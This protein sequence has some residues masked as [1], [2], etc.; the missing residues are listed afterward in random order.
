MNSKPIMNSST[1]AGSITFNNV[2]LPIA[3]STSPPLFGV[4]YGMQK[5]EF[6]TESA[7]DFL[8]RNPSFLHLKFNRTFI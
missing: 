6:G 2:R 5:S 1:E 7:E 8:K 4:S 3:G